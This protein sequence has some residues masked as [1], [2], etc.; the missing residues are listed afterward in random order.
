M[1]NRRGFSCR[2][3]TL[4]QVNSKKKEDAFFEGRVQVVIAHGSGAP[5]LHVDDGNDDDGGTENEDSKS[6]CAFNCFVRRHQH[7]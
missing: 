5:V 7:R 1:R 4:I 2:R 3:Q 6:G